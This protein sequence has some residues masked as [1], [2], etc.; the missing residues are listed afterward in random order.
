MTIK[1]AELHVHLEGTISPDLAL[2]IAKRNLLTLPDGLISEDGTCYLSD[3]FLHFLKVYDV[4]ADIIK[5]PLDY[6]DITYDYLKNC[7][8]GGA[9][10]VEMMYSP[11]HAENASGIASIEHLKELDISE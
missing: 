7:A 2:K 11:D 4:V 1:Q 9:I 8:K 10:Y 3:D 6:Y 5:T